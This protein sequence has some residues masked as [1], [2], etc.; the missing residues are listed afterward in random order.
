MNYSTLVSDLFNRFPELEEVYH[1][2]FAYMASEEPAPYVVF[3][4]ILI[5]ALITGLERADREMIARLCGFLE[6]V[7][8]AARSDLSL[9]GLMKVEV[10]EWLG[11]AA[12]EERLAPSLGPETKRICNYVPGLATQR[13]EPRNEAQERTVFARAASFVRRLRM[14]SAPDPVSIVSSTPTAIVGKEN[15]RRMRAQIRRV[16]LEVSD[17]IGIRDEP[18]AQDEYDSYVGRLYELLVGNASDAELSDF[19]HGVAHDR[20]GFEEAKA[21]DAQPT[22]EALKSIPI[23]G[24]HI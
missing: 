10:A 16:L 2:D 7:S 21:S 17:P 12:S 8:L 9:L 18:N 15:S 20:M 14:A 24:Q 1:R 3:G 4:S 19:L 22:V 23:Q 5:P 11:S 13:R 6:D